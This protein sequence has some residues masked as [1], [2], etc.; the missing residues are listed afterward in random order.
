MNL[1]GKIALVTGGSDGIG[2]A[3]ALKL[4][5]EGAQVAICG[6]TESTLRSAREELRSRGIEVSQFLCDV[7]MLD[8]VEEMVRGLAEERGRIDILVNNAG[9]L[10][11]TPLNPGSDEAWNKVVRTNLDGV[12]Y[13]TSRVLA[14]MPEGGRIISI[15]SV[16]GK[17]GVPGAAAYCASKHGVIGF[18]KSVALE[19]AARQITVNAICPGWVETQLARLVM[20]R[21]AAKLGTG[22]DEFRESAL[23]QVPLKK[24]IQPEEVAS[25]VSFLASPDGKNITGQAYSLCGGQ[26]MF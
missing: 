12:Y 1:E 7:T 18:T 20:D 4:G 25:L 5:G 8:Q 21:A 23:E 3:I 14:H 22:F 24:M 13:V 15:S 16:L 2:K 6:R 26:T 9:A 10:E 11:D 17:I 19:V